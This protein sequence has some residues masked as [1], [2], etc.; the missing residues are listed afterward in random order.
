MTDN[1]VHFKTNFEQFPSSIEDSINHLV[2]V[3]QDYCDEVSDDILEAV[4]SVLHSYGFQIKSEEKHIKD[5]VFLEE[6]IKALLYRYK[7][8]PHG[9]HD[10]IDATITLT[11]EAS[12][13]LE[14]IKKR[15]D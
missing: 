4:T 3:R 15:V 13:E 8:I 5:I 11:A 2:S 14:K 10:V 12:D 6:A 7:K 1:I 9:M